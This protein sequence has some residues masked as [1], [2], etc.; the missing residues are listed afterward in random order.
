MANQRDCTD[1]LPEALW[2]YRIAWWSTKIFSPFKLVYGKLPIF[3]IEFEINTLRKTVEV[4]LDLPRTQK[5]KLDQ[6]NDLD[7][8]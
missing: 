1:R 7:E 2:A 4:E 5:H 6:I 8:I 3:S